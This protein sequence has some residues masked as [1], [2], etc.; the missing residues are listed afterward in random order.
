MKN[1]VNT[2][3]MV[4]HFFSIEVF[5]D[6]TRLTKRVPDMWDSVAFS[7]I[8][9]A[10]GFSLLPTR[11]HTHNLLETVLGFYHVTTP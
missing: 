4:S 9:L 5:R 8:F 3:I 10:S 7:N 1:L 2:K 11:V 6:Q